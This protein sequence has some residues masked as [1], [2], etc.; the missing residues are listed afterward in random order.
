MNYDPTQIAALV[1]A[2]PDLIPAWVETLHA[3][4]HDAG[5][6]PVPSRSGKVGR[7][8]PCPC[9]SGR[10]YKKCRGPGHAIGNATPDAVK[11]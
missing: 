11:G 10:K 4:H 8:G 1:N 6:Q 9:G 3:R 2:A 7:N 5:A